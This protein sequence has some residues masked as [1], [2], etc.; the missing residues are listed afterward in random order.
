MGKIFAENNFIR[1][2]WSLNT[3]QISTGVNDMLISFTE[4]LPTVS[5][6]NLN[7]GYELRLGDNIKSY[8]V[9]PPRG[10]T[11]KKSDQE[12]LKL[13]RFF[14][15]PEQPYMLYLW[16]DNNGKRTEKEFEIVAFTV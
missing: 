13:V 15:N 11:Y 7:F 14:L 4:E 6:N 16:S 2:T 12:Y 3:E 9:Y 8:G 1:A 5:F 10:V